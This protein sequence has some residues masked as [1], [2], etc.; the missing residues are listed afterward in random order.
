MR[1]L[2]AYGREFVEPRPYT[3]DVLAQAAGMSVSGVRTAYDDDHINDV[4]K[5]I[6]ARLRRREDTEPHTEPQPE[7]TAAAPLS[8]VDTSGER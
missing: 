1:L 2:L 6:G 5:R 3:L 7:V 8:A 4:R